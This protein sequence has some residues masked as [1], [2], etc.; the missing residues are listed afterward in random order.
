M[1]IIEKIKNYYSISSEKLTQYEINNI[2]EVY[3]RELKA[4]FGKN[5]ELF[6]EA[7]QYLNREG[8]N[9]GTWH[10]IS[11]LQSMIDTVGKRIDV[12]DYS[13]ANLSRIHHCIL[14][15]QI[16][17]DK[18]NLKKLIAVF[19]GNPDKKPAAFT[20]AKN[21]E[22]HS[23]ILELLK[24][25][26]NQL[27]VIE[28]I[29]NYMTYRIS[30]DEFKK[31]I[32]P[33]VIELQ[34]YRYKT[35]AEN[36]VAGYGMGFPVTNA[37]ESVTSIWDIVSGNYQKYLDTKDT[38]IAYSLLCLLYKVDPKAHEKY[39]EKTLAANDKNLRLIAYYY[40]SRRGDSSKLAERYFEQD[41]LE[42]YAPILDSLPSYLQNRTEEDYKGVSGEQAKLFRS[43][44]TKLVLLYE[45][46]PKK[47][48]HYNISD[49]I[50][51]A[52]E[53]STD[54]ILLKIIYIF[55]SLRD[56]TLT[57]HFEDNFYDK[58][59]GKDKLIFINALEAQ[60]KHNYRAEM[61]NYFGVYFPWGDNYKKYFAENPLSYGEAVIVSDFLKSKRNEIKKNITEHFQKM[62]DGDRKKLKGYLEGSE[63][64]YKRECAKDLSGGGEVITPREEKV[65]L[66][67]KSEKNIGGGKIKT[68]V[69]KLTEFIKANQNYEYKTEFSDEKYLFGAKHVR[70]NG[71]DDFPLEKEV[72][73]VISGS[74]LS[75]YE[76]AAFA[77]SV[78]GDAGNELVSLLASI[79]KNDNT[80]SDSQKLLGNH[81]KPMLENYIKKSSAPAI[82]DALVERIILTLGKVTEFPKN[83][84]ERIVFGY[85][86]KEETASEKLMRVAQSLERLVNPAL[87]GEEGLRNCE[88]IITFCKQNN[89]GHSFGNRL[90]YQMFVGGVITAEK[91]AYL[92]KT[93]IFE[94]HA[95]LNIYP[96]QERD[97]GRYVCI[98][99]PD[100]RE[101]FKD[102]VEKILMEM[103]ETEINRAEAVTIYTEILRRCT[104]FVGVK[105]Y[106]LALKAFKKMTLPRGYLYGTTKDNSFARILENVA[107][108]KT[109][110]YEDFERLI[111]E[112]GLNENDLVKGVLYNNNATLLE[113]TDKFL[114]KKG[115]VSAV[116]FFKAHL[117]DTEVGREVKD[118]IAQY[119]GIDI[120]D[121]KDG[122]V[123]V[124]WF[125]SM[126]NETDQKTFDT[127]YDNAK[128]I[129][130][131][132]LHKRAQRFTDAL[133]GKLTAA[134]CLEK[135]NVNRDKEFVLYYSLVPLHGKD[136]ISERYAVV[137]KFLQGSKQFG[138]QRQAS[139]KKAS[140]IALENIARVAGYD[141]VDR[142]IWYMESLDA[143]Q[144]A[145]YFEPKTIEDTTVFLRVNDRYK[146][147]A[148]AEKNGKELSAIPAKLKADKY[149]AQMRAAV[150]ELNKQSTRVVKSLEKAMES[151]SRFTHNE[152]I[153]MSANPVIKHI[154]C[155]LFFVA[156]G[157]AAM[158][159]G[160]KFV[161]FVSGE[162]LTAEEVYIAH[163]FDLY[164][165]KCWKAAQKYLL[166]NKIRQ[167]FK[168]AFRE[169]Y[170]KTADEINDTRT[171]RYHGHQISA[172][173]AIAVAKGRGWHT[174]E[175][176]GLQKVYY[177]EDIIAVL[178]GVWDL[179]YS[180]FT[181]H[182]TISSVFFLNRR[183]LNIL[184]LKD[185][186]DKMFSEVMRDVD[187]IVATSH[188]LGYDF[189][190]SL[191]TVEV[192]RQI[193]QNIIELLSI[194]N[195]SV[196]GYHINI[197]GSYGDYAIN[198]KTGNAYKQ[199]SGALNIMA[200][201]DS[202][203]NKV[204]LNF[205]DDNPKTAEVV[206][207]MLLLADDQK[208]KDADILR[209]IKP[210]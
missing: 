120:L 142:F 80:M 100:V 136:E 43:L 204:F 108:H 156:D 4:A 66:P 23:Y 125:W 116:M 37:R 33:Q 42:F 163:P 53:V 18:K 79:Q 69:G 61:L 158:L 144:T 39:F 44:Y 153:A 149:V 15:A 171:N 27:G 185:I 178:F 150:P 193:C 35:V 6:R 16:D 147:E 126:K 184:P 81:I 115:F 49:E 161:D 76:I 186:G 8:G 210:H 2:F 127:V 152:L 63:E 191:S 159:R 124:D 36:I 105:Y 183:T 133:T 96:Y 48:L 123:D 113:W 54:E 109:D 50:W 187:L 148:V 102:A 30:S 98:Y 174:G 65:K 62:R 95:L 84:S 135:I 11:L 195:A 52:R 140:E 20:I 29:F 46:M 208:I 103:T 170:P 151:E 143:G 137:Q 88:A 41:D 207:K 188:P 154:L 165:L 155:S 119:S 71:N 82:D 134:E 9:D 168:Q 40:M 56:K 205:I 130:V 146:C 97:K 203:Q 117:R 78:Y 118:K 34:F 122:A 104:K 31:F 26:G 106:A 121:F 7:F 101:D 172:Q 197:K 145:L 190:E 107:P 110:T 38:K 141:D 139:E 132:N 189:E 83:T 138:A 3:K 13:P 5:F 196:E 175:D 112:N 22:G 58:L 169:L 74:G 73:E 51:F 21:A 60:I 90:L 176:V 45:K 68:L 93:Q 57:G 86:R 201:N 129:T 111:S 167:P 59:D 164:N 128:Y 28:G 87:L 94:L 99:S 12:Y 131:V 114:G 91:L 162:V 14:A 199:L 32:I 67:A 194:P 181:D 1:N 180:S 19:D 157:K 92:L 166:E 177:K 72:N 89:M 77:A 85:S 209:E 24:K 70:L 75:A 64:E 10:K 47:K 182:P 17:G 160:G 192:R 179:G 55:K 198:L 25:A 202:T 206:S 173:K 200:I